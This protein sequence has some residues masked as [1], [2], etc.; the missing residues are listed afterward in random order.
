MTEPVRLLVVSGSSEYAAR[1]L[2]ECDTKGIP[3]MAER[4]ASSHEMRAALGR[5][6]WDA[7]VSDMGIPRFDIED[8]VRL[9]KEAVPEVPVIVV[10]EGAGEEASDR[11]ICA[12]A[13]EFIPMT[14]LECA[15][16][17][18]ERVVREAE[19]R[20]E[21]SEATRRLSEKDGLLHTVVSNAPVVLL[22]AD[23]DGTVT[24]FE[25]KGVAVFGP[26]LRDIVGLNVF[27][28]LAGR[29]PALGE[30][31]RRALAGEKVSKLVSVSTGVFLDTQCRPLRD[32]DG[33][34]SG[35]ICI[36]TDVT[37]RERARQALAESEARYRALVENTND[38]P[39]AFDVTG[40]ITYV[41]PQV[42]RLGYAP[43][44]VVSRSIFD[45]VNEEDQESVE[46]DF[47]RTMETGEEFPTEFRMADRDGRLVWYEEIGKVQRDDA[48]RITGV[49]GV[50]RNVT[51]R[52]RAEEELRKAHDELEQRVEE[53]TAE[54][55]I[56]ND[57]L[58]REIEERK[59]AE[60]SL[61]FA[62]FSIE[63]SG[64]PT[65]WIGRD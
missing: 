48:G 14:E 53:R 31:C 49:V 27:R 16:C 26:E 11:A 61:R 45:F 20:R 9:A 42:E 60:E 25:G 15:V 51:G 52:K 2:R 21:R 62:E 18:V 36:A 24:L 39:V 33:E 12:G 19:A 3:A 4:V 1:I 55:H 65:F 40:K 50:L 54:L 8:V 63:R 37:E 28:D 59:A 56:V 64:E 6:R 35:V 7:V 17:A 41:G 44:E 47:R 29:C 58:R 57:D 23:R 46:A 34:V 10:S 22:A 32:E 38:M 5:G 43:D 13:A 30:N